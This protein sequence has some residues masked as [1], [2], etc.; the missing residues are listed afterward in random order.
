MNV[1]QESFHTESLE[2]HSQNQSRV[3][4]AAHN[5]MVGSVEKFAYEGLQT[6]VPLSSQ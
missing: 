2:V 1:E 4:D 6:A 5:C 3:D